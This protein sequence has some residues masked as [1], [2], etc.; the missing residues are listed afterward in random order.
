MTIML[1]V[2]WILKL[3]SIKKEKS[4]PSVSF[5]IK[6]RSSKPSK[7]FLTWFSFKVISSDVYDSIWFTMF[8]LQILFMELF[9][10]TKSHTTAMA[11]S[12]W[13][14]STLCLAHA[15]QGNKFELE[16]CVKLFLHLF[17][18]LIL[19]LLSAL[20]SSSSLLARQTTWSSK[21][22]LQLS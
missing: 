5:M 20:E 21:Q 12:A 2:I 13:D 15:S 14:S 22:K 4:S 19:E 16:M 8:S 10:D 7:K 9:V 3:S 6:R 1:D 18:L 11:T 17:A